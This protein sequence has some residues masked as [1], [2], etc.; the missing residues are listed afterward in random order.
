MVYW[1]RDSRFFGTAHRKTNSLLDGRQL[2][3]EDGGAGQFPCLLLNV[4][5]G[6]P[7]LVNLLLQLLRLR[8][9]RLVVAQQRLVVQQR[10]LLG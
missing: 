7:Q 1:W 5:A 2:L 4:L 8:L 6:L 10:G 3:L 9:L